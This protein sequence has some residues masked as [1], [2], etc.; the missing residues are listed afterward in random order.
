[1]RRFV[2]AA[3]AMLVATAGFAQH[4][5]KNTLSFFISQAT[6]SSASYAVQGDNSNG[7]AFDRMLTKRLSAQVWITSERHETFGYVVRPDGS[8]Q[9]T[10][11]VLFRT[12]PVDFAMK[13]H[14]VN[15]TRWKPYLGIGARYVSAPQEGA[16]FRRLN[17]VRPEVL[18]GTTF[19]F[20]P[21]FGVFVDGRVYFAN[22]HHYD[23]QF[24]PSL[25]LS[26]RF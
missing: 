8:I 19:Q 11:R 6:L 22:S 20:T 4:E 24:K 18:G 21:H 2:I 12:Y 13:Y 1:M 23:E 14:F 3:V 9:T 26:W 25:G 7:L 15:E 10:E 16:E 17:I 5:Q